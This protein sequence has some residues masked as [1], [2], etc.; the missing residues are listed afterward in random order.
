MDAD[1]A[2]GAMEVQTIPPLGAVEFEM[3]DRSLPPIISIT[4]RIDSSLKEYQLDPTKIEDMAR[5][6]VDM[7]KEGTVSLNCYLKLRKT[8]LDYCQS[9]GADEAVTIFR[10]EAQGRTEVIVRARRETDPLLVAGAFSEGL[11]FLRA[12]VS[13]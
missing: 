11:F 4:V 3:R 13:V 6:A 9:Q 8:I 10:G 7:S 2:D 1:D 5:T 12:M